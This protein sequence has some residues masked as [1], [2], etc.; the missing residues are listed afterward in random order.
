MDVL[1]SLYFFSL[2]LIG[3]M[4]KYPIV[5]NI[6]ASIE[7]IYNALPCQNRTSWISTT[8]ILTSC[9][10]IFLENVSNTALSKRWK[11]RWSPQ[12]YTDQVR[13]VKRPLD[14]LRLTEG[15]LSI[16]AAH[17]A[18]QNFLRGPFFVTSSKRPGVFNHAAISW[19]S[20][21]SMASFWL[22]VNGGLAISSPYCNCLSSRIASSL[23]P[24]PSGSTMLEV[25]I[26]LA[27]IR[28]IVTGSCLGFRKI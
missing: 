8:S 24:L 28:W 13:K 17:L 19:I 10:G 9:Q 25:G 4:A 15:P 12:S 20:P 21:L 23:V 22:R 11:R 18:V 7:R 1:H 6:I 2:C 16:A 26:P 3:R 5:Y 27:H 14:I